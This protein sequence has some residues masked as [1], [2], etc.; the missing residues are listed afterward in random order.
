MIREA[1][2]ADKLRLVEMATRFILTSSY[3]QWLQVVPEKIAAHVD[4]LLEHGVIFV[5]EIERPC[6]MEKDDGTG[7]VDDNDVCPDCSEV[8][9]MLALVGP[10]E[11]IDGRTY[12]EEVAWWVEPEHRKTTLGPR[13]M[14][15]MEHWCGQK[16]V[17]MVKM[18]APVDSSVGDFYAKC[19]YQAVEMAWVKVFR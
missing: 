9:G 3:S 5:A 19:G 11:L 13:L 12:A 17:Y 2:V 14:H 15:K 8:V 7:Y 18:L 4:T 10:V 6:A 16:S 1:T